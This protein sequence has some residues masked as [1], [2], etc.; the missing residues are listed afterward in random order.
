M[1]YVGVEWA[2]FLPTKVIKYGGTMCKLE[3]KY[4]V[5]VSFEKKTL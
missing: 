4:K 2:S 5:D 1:K 3:C